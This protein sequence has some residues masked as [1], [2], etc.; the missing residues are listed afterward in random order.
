MSD[1]DERT[2]RWWAGQFRLLHR[3]TFASELGLE[4]ACTNTGTAPLRLEEALQ[5][6]NR[7]YRSEPYPGPAVNLAPGQEPR[8]T[9]VLS[10]AKF[11]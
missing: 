5:T 1:S 9:G 11:G 4:L 6:Y 10:L 7:V 8:M 3:A 2:Q